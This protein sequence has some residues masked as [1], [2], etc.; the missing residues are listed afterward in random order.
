MKQRKSTNLLVAGSRSRPPREHDSCRYCRGCCHRHRGSERSNHH[1][2]HAVVYAGALYEFTPH[3]MTGTRCRAP[4]DGDLFL[5]EPLI[6]VRRNVS[7][8]DPGER[9]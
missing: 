9:F 3:I 2:G 6:L 5:F 8:S 1:R 4:R 7:D